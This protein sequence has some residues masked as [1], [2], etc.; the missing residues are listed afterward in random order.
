MAT[1][2][3]YNGYN[4]YETWMIALWIDND[5]Y[6]QEAVHELAEQ[7]ADDDGDHDLGG[8]SSAIKDF[9]EEMP[10]V[11]GAI[12]K[13]GIVADMVNSTLSSVDWYELA[14]MYMKEYQ[15]NQ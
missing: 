13:G 5:Q 12:E 14:E 7:H 15:E 2:E 8:Y 6:Y 9:V 11:A 10:D 3:K 4:N 1:G